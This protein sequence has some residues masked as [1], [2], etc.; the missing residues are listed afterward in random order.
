MEKSLISQVNLKEDFILFKNCFIDLGKIAFVEERQRL[1]FLSDEFG[2]ETNKA[3]H[4]CFLLR[5]HFIGNSNILSFYT[6]KQFDAKV[7]Q[8]DNRELA[9]GAVFI[10]KESEYDTFKAFLTKRLKPEQV[11]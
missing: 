5:L 4:A 9:E 10:E 7:D 6:T 8:Y 11:K 2:G 1:Y 3:N